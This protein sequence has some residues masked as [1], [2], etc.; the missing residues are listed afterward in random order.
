MSHGFVVLNARI[1]CE[2]MGSD[3]ARKRRARQ[4]EAQF[5]KKSMRRAHFSLGGG[6]GKH[7]ARV[8]ETVGN[9]KDD[10]MTNALRKMLAMKEG[11]KFDRHDSGRHQKKS[12]ERVVKAPEKDASVDE[13]SPPPKGGSVD[14]EDGRR[15]ITRTEKEEEKKTSASK[16]KRKAFMKRK[17]KKTKDDLYEPDVKLPTGGAP[18]FGEQAERPIEATLKRRHWVDSETPKPLTLSMKN[19]GSRMDSKALAALYRTSRKGK[20]AHQKQAAT[21]ETLKQLVKSTTTDAAH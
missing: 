20:M 18:A 7:S 15:K 16:L 4:L 14:D 9:R 3:K 10:G 11:R 19:V 13:S 5:E 1:H 8:E 2:N 6:V 17:G 12:Q 21:M